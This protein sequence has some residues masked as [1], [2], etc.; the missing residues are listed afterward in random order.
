MKL[1]ELINS[2]GEVTWMSTREIFAS[3][4]RTE[5]AGTTLVIHPYSTDFSGEGS[6]RCLGPDDCVGGTLP[7]F[8]R[9]RAGGTRRDAPGHAW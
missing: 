6:H 5:V 2:L 8:T 3:N 1:A 9:G 7:S 4:F